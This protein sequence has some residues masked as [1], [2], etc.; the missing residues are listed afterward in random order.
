M[1]FFYAML[2]FASDKNTLLKEVIFE[3]LPPSFL[4]SPIPADI[5]MIEKGKNLTLRKKNI[6][7]VDIEAAQAPLSMF[8]DTVF[9]STVNFQEYC[10]E[11][12][13]HLNNAAAIAPQSKDLALKLTQNCKT[14]AEKITVIRDY[15][16]KQ[17]RL[18]GP[19][20]NDYN[21][22][23][24]PADRTLKRSY[25]NSADRAVLLKAMLNAAGFKVEW[26]A[27][28]SLGYPKLKNTYLSS[29]LR[30]FQNIYDRIILIVYENN[31]IV[32]V[33]NENSRFAPVTQDNNRS[34]V[35]LNLTRKQPQPRTEIRRTINQ[36][37][38]DITLD[39]KPDLSVEADIVYS[40]YG[41]QAE[42]MRRFFAESNQHQIDRFYQSST[43]AFSRNAVI[44][45]PWKTDD[46][47]T[48][49][50]LKC[51][52]NIKN[53]ISVTGKF[54]SVPLPFISS[55]GQRI[56]S[57]T[58]RKTPLWFNNEFSTQLNI[59]IRLPQNYTPASKIPLNI[60]R[61]INNIFGFA[62]IR[63]IKN[64][65]VSI[66]AAAVNDIGF[67]D[68]ENAAALAPLKK[69]TDSTDLNYIFLKTK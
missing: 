33:L 18:A 69:L 3:N 15:V 62:Y 17:I 46:N 66:T 2:T 16:D 34:R 8:N 5:E 50:K 10:S 22:T 25:G 57:S 51:V 30:Y 7:R 43:T 1:P 27:R 53:Y 67:F 26:A 42:S 54:A 21:W 35:T 37:V 31:K 59:K 48:I 23:F 40:F 61:N 13:K 29:I 24:S 6:R 56:P 47:G 9:C 49:F 60:I 4:C 41:D 68:P 14:S 65:T 19:D 32:A 52:L 45:T 36:T 38:K 11:L 12:V 39:I 28:S 20:L 63:S 55:L 64:N 44:K 58:E